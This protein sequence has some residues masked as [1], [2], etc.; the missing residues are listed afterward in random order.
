MEPLLSLARK[1]LHH[2]GNKALVQLRNLRCLTGVP[3]LYRP[4][5]VVGCSRSGTT[6]VYKTFSESRQLGSLQ[7]ETHDF[8]ASLHTPEERNWDTH[9]IPESFASESDRRLVSRF[10]YT[11][12]GH[13]RFVDTNN[14]NG[15]SISYLHALFPD[16]HFVFIKRSPGDN[17]NSLIHGWGK[18]D[19]FATW[20]RRLSETVEIENGLYRNWCFFL[21]DGWRQYT[22]SSI[23]EVCAFQYRALNEAILGART[24]IPENQWHEL[25]YEELIADPVEGFR[26]VFHASGLAFDDHLERHCRQVL[27]NP[28]NAFSEI[29]VDKWKESPNRVKIERALPIVQET[30]A[31]L[32]Y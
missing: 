23:E 8:W 20:S 13:T 24:K 25:F 30:A 26:A 18:A 14:Q 29:R 32:G 12:T 2:Y 7:K 9:E 5:F 17:I 28:Y 11:S 3:R 16:A 27:S 15:L 6:L 21:A 1:N 19:E 31:K 22:R 10:F 4:V